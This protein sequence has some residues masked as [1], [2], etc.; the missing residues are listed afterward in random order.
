M[1]RVYAVIEDLDA[2]MTNFAM[3]QKQHVADVCGDPY[4]SVNAVL[5][6]CNRRVSLRV[7]ERHRKSYSLQ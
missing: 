6:W 3:R 7:S 2:Q 4:P 1:T 5:L